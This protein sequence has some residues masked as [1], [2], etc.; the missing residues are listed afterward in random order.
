MAPDREEEKGEA[1]PS[2]GLEV[3]YDVPYLHCASCF[4]NLL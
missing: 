1:Q 2:D 3:N 4:H